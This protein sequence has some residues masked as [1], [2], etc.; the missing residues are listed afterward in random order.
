M[1]GSPRV[2]AGTTAEA[3]GD[4]EKDAEEVV[5]LTIFRQT[6]LEFINLTR[7]EKEHIP[8]G[9]GDVGVD[10]SNPGTKASF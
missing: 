5:A 4:E 6:G 7:Y 10:A 1:A 2:H 9:I 8:D 3:G